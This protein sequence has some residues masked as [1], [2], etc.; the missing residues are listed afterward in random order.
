MSDTPPQI[1]C[2]ICGGFPTDRCHIRSRGAGGSDEEFNL[3]P[4]CREHHSEQHRMG[5]MSFYKKYPRFQV[6]LRRKGWTVE[7]ILGKEILTNPEL[8]RK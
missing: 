3:F 5:L 8:Y 4:A 1:F 6:Y 2:V 7:V